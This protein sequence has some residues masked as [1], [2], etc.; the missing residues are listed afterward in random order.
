M[1][2]SEHI[3][4]YIS[5]VF[6]LRNEAKILHFVSLQGEVISDMYF[7]YAEVLYMYYI[8]TFLCEIKSNLE[9]SFI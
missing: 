3:F 9:K 2:G 7:F 4:I 6:F 5:V 8:S 1:M